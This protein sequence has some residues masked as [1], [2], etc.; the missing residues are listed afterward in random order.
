MKI[1]DNGLLSIENLMPT[2]LDMDRIL[3]RRKLV[4]RKE[5]KDSLRRF[6]AGLVGENTVVEY[7]KEY[8]RKHWVVLR[9]LWLN[10]F[11]AC[12]CDVVLLTGIGIHTFE[13]KNYVGEFIYEKGTCT[14]NGQTIK[15]NCLS[16]AA[17]A[18][19]TLREVC[20]KF[21]RNTPVSGALVFA[22]TDNDVEIRSPFDDVQVV[23]R[24]GLR[25]H[26]QNIAHAEDNA[27]YTSTIDVQGIIQHLTNIAVPNPYIPTPLSKDEMASLWKGICCANCGNFDVEIGRQYVTCPCG[28][29]EPR[30]EAVIRTIC[31]YGVLT[32]DQ[33]M[34]RADLLD[35]FGGDISKHIFRKIM[36]K[37]FKC[38]YKNR[39]TTYQNFRLPYDKIKHFFVIDLPK[40]LYINKKDYLL[41]NS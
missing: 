20:R 27:H 23:A 6:E 13:V 4:V 5:Q 2:Q 36:N 11:G 10:D 38:S 40:I 34:N 28:L 1:Y 7:L 30:D 18:Q 32:Y 33:A 12:E 26:I 31:E 41:I 3:T 19:A 21:S 24:S 16:Q 25:K 37:F 15:H 39:Y 8:G 9:N 14:L 22:G 17:K 35:F 29:H